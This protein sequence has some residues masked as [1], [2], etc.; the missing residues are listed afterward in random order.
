LSEVQSP[1]QTSGPLYGYAL[2]FDGSANAVDPD[3]PGA[4]RVRG[5][6]LD[7]DGVPVAYPE[8]FL[9]LWVGEQWC[10]T[11]TDEDGLYTAVIRKPSSPAS[12]DGEPQAPHV[13]VTVF[14]RGLLK[15]AQTRI[16]F[17]DEP[18]ANA[19]DPVLRLVP[20]DARDT[21]LARPAADGSLRF[22]IHLQGP[23]ETAFFDF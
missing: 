13:N 23:H 22:D 9:E 11:R 5:L 15:Q 21:L 1:S 10:R 3:S 16:Y 7:G 2:M 18:R 6:V 19:S 14:A 17:P 4:L 20:E 8:C 12:L